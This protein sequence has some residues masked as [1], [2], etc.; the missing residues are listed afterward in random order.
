MTL[1]NPNRFVT[2]LA[3]ASYVNSVVRVDTSDDLD[4]VVVTPNTRVETVKVYRKPRTKD[5][6]V[7]DPFDNGNE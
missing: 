2:G 3:D 6:F 1:R 7:K 5:Q 4:G